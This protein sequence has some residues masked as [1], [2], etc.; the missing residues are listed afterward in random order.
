[1]RNSFIL[2]EGEKERI[3]K[4]YEATS[5]S[6]SGA[7]EQPMAWSETEEV[8]IEPTCDG[9][10]NIVDGSEE[11]TIDFDEISELLGL[12]EEEQ[13]ERIRKT[14]EENYI[15]NKKDK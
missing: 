15:I 12:S 14:Q 13:E 4:L 1:M 9:G 11:I 7:F 5:A 2:L 8:T 6:A 3:R 10:D